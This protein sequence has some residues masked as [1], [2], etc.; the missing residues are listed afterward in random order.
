MRK[1]IIFMCIS[2]MAFA[3]LNIF[4]KRLEDF[5]VYQI[6]F[7]RSIGTLFFTIPLILKLKLNLLGN[8]RKLLVARGLI[9]F[10]AMTLFFMSLKYLTTGTAVSIR[11]ISPIFAAFFALFILKEKIK[12]IQW[13]YFGIAFIGVFILK[14]FDGEILNIGLLYIVVSAIFTGLVFIIIRKIGS[15]DHPLIIVTYFMVISTL[16]S[17]LF[18][19]YNWTN[20]SGIEWL[21]LLS[22]GVFGYFG[23][24]YM[25]KA[26][27][28]SEINRIAPLKYI[29]VIF[30]MLI[31]LI[32]LDETYTLLSVLGIILILIGLTLNTAIKGLK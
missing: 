19:Y 29:E 5:N 27:Q 16:I 20:P 30:T 28:E 15:K 7:F 24:Y 31:G 13:F 11:Y 3:L 17:S 22:L 12:S 4:V 23:Q 1:A 25:T 21:I 8:K 2:A 10:V 18:T 9:G 32:W 14:G 26:L 6:V